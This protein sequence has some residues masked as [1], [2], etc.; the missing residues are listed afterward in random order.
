VLKRLYLLRHGEADHPDRE[1]NDDSK[2]PLTKQ[3]R[4]K[5]EE[6]AR[7]MKALRIAIDEIVTSP[8][9]RA[10]QTA[11]VVAEAYRLIDRMTY[12]EHLEPGASL[13]DLRRSLAGLKGESVLVVGHAPDL[14]HLVGRISG[15]G[16][17]HL[18]KGAM[19]WIALDDGSAKEN[20]GRLKALLPADLL[21]AAGRF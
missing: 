15:I 13:S 3:G 4:E 7:G 21:A 16:E 12:S 2:R 18:G 5:M 6:E 20:S 11:D 17:V 19:A 1:W 10:R 9:V 8:Y 14:G